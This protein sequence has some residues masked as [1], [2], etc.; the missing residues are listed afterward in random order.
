MEAI[1]WTLRRHGYAVVNR[2]YPWRSQTIARIASEWLPAQLAGCA[3]SRLHFVTHSMGGIVV[4]QWLAS[5]G[6]PANLGRIVMLAP[7]N[8]GSELPDRFKTFAP[9]RWVLG[10]NS[11]A[12]G[13]APHNLPRALGQ[14]PAHRHALGII[15]GNRSA[16]PFLG[17]LVPK[18]HDGKVSVAATHLA[19]ER[20]HITLPFSHPWLGWRRPTLRQ[21][22]AFLREGRFDR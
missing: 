11:V 15:A 7:P 21:I 8:G 10:P 9:Y 14:W 22:V 1:A 16:N 18:P 4:R 6:A 17:Q 5:C 20:D 19:G 13:C 12:L 2:S 3:G